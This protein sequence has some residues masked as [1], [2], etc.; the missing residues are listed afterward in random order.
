VRFGAIRKSIN[1]LIQMS[2][3]QGLVQEIAQDFKEDLRF[4]STA[5]L[6]TQESAKAYLVG[7]LEDTNLCAIHDKHVTVMPKDM[8]L[9]CRICGD[10]PAK[11]P[12]PKK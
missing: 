5:M 12:L 2:P 10:P 7:V 9:A 11:D 3:F 4:Q 6:A 8:Q 1:L